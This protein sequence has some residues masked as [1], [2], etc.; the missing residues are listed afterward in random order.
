MRRWRTPTDSR[1]ATNPRTGRGRG[2]CPRAPAMSKPARPGSESVPRSG[3]L[4]INRLDPLLVGGVRRK[5]IELLPVELVAGADIDRLERVEHVELGQGYPG[6]SADSD[7]LPHE[8]S[9]EPA[10]PA[11]SPG[12][13]AEL[14]AAL[15]ERVARLVVLLG[16]EWTRADAGRVGLGDAE[17]E[18]RRRR[19]G[20]ASRRAAPCRGRARSGGRRAARRSLSRR[21][22]L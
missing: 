6:D 8:D 7:C 18:A 11:L 19:A 14:A 10:A 12:D 15:A 20:T 21:G 22:R 5:I 3:D 9:V 16:G 2:S 4:G 17:D 1:C 13:G